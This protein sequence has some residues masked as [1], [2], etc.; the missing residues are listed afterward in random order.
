MGGVRDDVDAAAADDRHAHHGAALAPGA[1]QEAEAVAAE[2][3]EAADEGQ[4]VE[5]GQGATGVHA[6]TRGEEGEG[7]GVRA[8]LA[9]TR[10]AIHSERAEMVMTGW[11]PMEVGTTAPSAT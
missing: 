8:R 6:C 4:A 10:S 2:L 11:L 5:D 1:Q 3:G 9:T 7:R